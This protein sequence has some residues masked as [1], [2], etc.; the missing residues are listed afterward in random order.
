M[1]PTTMAQKQMALATTA[2]DQPTHRFTNLYRLLH[3]DGWLRCAADAVLARPGSSTAGVDGQTRLYF[4]A[5]YEEQLATLRASLKRKT[6]RPQPGRRTYIPKKNGKKRPL[7]IATLRDRVVQEALRMILDPIFESDFRPHSYGF[8]KGRCTMDAIAVMMPLFNTSSKYYYVI[9]GDIKSYFDTVQHRKLLHLL[10]RR[11]ADKDLITLIWQFLKAGVMEQG[12]VAR[13]EAGVPQGAGISPLLANVYLHE[14]DVWAEQQWELSRAERLKRR[15]SGRGN[16]RLI[17]YADDFCVVSNDGIAGVREAK[18]EI[19][20]FLADELHLEL[21][22]DKTRITHVNDGFDFLGFHIQRVRPEGRWVVHLRPT[23]EAT[24]RV[25]AKIKRLTTRSW[26]WL[27]EYTRLTTLNST[28]RNWASYYRFASLQ[29]DIED[30]TRY[31]WHRYLRWLRKKHKGSRSGQLIRAKTG[32]LHNRTRWTAE[33]R[34]GATTLRAYQW[35]ATG[36][37]FPRRRYPQKGRE[38]FA[39]PYLT[40]G[41]S[42][43]ADYP[44]GETG[45]NEQL[46]ALAIGVPSR[47]P[48]RHEPHDMVERELRAKL[49][50]GFTC[51]RCGARSTTLHVHHRKGSRSHRLRDLATLCAACHKTVHYGQRR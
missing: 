33:I 34:Q 44:L 45:P 32:R 7:G 50:D 24:A 49:R 5:T 38:G 47:N 13:T 16:Y 8:R 51:T 3:W 22:D 23:A 12:L 18:A 21:S 25:K 4:K 46:Y 20:C 43:A 6:Y 41:C 15:T 28:V 1:S 29:R 14:F 27:D 2:R 36:T 17:R 30:V 9:E 37:E 11:V 48:R 26:V 31:T 19:K 39:H 35:L 42:A 10:K 40:E